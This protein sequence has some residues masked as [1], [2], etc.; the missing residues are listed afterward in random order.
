[1]T[2]LGVLAVSGLTFFLAVS[3]VS[4]HQEPQATSASPETSPWTPRGTAQ[5]LPAFIPRCVSVSGGER[6]RGKPRPVLAAALRGGR[7][8]A[9]GGVFALRGLPRDFSSQKPP[10]LPDGAYWR[11]RAGRGP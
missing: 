11:S 5:R 4:G 10:R 2:S 7:C 6:L 8:A 3:S 1:M 9:G